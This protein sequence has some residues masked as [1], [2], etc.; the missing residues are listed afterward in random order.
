MNC[1]MSLNLLGKVQIEI[2]TKHVDH[3]QIIMTLEEEQI[4]MKGN[5]K[6]EMKLGGLET[7][8]GVIHLKAKY[9]RVARFSKMWEWAR[10]Q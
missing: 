4:T 10:F 3:P 5:E 7:T 6:L 2:K 8:T 9:C 1:L